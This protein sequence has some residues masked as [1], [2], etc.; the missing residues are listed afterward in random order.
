MSGDVTVIDLSDKFVLPGLMDMHVHL[1]GELGPNSR[2]DALHVTTSMRGLKGAMHAKRTL[3]TGFMTVR[4]L[5][6]KPEAIYALRDS[7]NNRFVS[8]SGPRMQKRTPLAGRSKLH[9]A[10][11]FADTGLMRM[12][13]LPVTT[14]LGEN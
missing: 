9:D 3:H 1:L 14:H 12:H 6:G 8:G 10:L 5:G 4:D 2:T 7:I 11:L 13:D